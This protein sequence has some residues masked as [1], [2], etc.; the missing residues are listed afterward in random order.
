MSTRTVCDVCERYMEKGEA[1]L[2]IVEFTHRST[3]EAPETV[4]LNVV[5]LEDRDVCIP[6]QLRIVEEGVEVNR[7]A[8]KSPTFSHSFVPTELH[9]RTLDIGGE[10][11]RIGENG[12]DTETD[13][14]CV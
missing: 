10:H 8:Y 14:S 13:N 7:I 5:V 12:E 1:M 2:P 3:S 4:E 11:V 6:C 9:H